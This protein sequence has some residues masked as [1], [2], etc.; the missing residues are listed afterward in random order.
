[1]CR[2]SNLKPPTNTVYLYELGRIHTG[3]RLVV[4][5]QQGALFLAAVVGPEGPSRGG[6]GRHRKDYGRSDGHDGYIVVG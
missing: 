2:G 3:L 5:P 4:S 1:M 6:E